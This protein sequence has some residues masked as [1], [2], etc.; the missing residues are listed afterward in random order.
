MTWPIRPGLQCACPSI[1]RISDIK[2]VVRVTYA[3]YKLLGSAM[4]RGTTAVTKMEM[5]IRF[6]RVF[7]NE[8]LIS[9][10]TVESR[11]TMSV[12]FQGGV[13]LVNCFCLGVCF[14]FRPCADR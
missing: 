2:Y 6:A 5:T 3:V 9:E 11:T 12:P 14:L 1:P 10:E 8:A 13:L 7:R 4:D